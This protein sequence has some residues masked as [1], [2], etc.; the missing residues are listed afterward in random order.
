MN[1]W[2]PGGVHS[3]APAPACAVLAEAG[4]RQ[5]HHSAPAHGVSLLY[6]IIL[7]L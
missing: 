2:F 3:P 7:L 1:P 5:V 4:L 6:Y